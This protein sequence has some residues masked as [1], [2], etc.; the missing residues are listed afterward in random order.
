[1]TKLCAKT[2]CVTK[3]CVKEGV[4]DAEVAEEAEEAFRTRRRDTELPKH[5]QD[6]PKKR[7]ENPEKSQPRN[8]CWPRK[9]RWPV[10][11]W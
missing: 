8:G 4:C 7:P 3:L 2:M 5:L 9:L 11:P 10:F 6:E 1:M